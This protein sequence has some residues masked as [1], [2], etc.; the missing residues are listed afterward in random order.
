MAMSAGMAIAS[1]VFASL[2]SK[3][4]S[5]GESFLLAISTILDAFAALSCTQ[6]F[7]VDSNILAIALSITS[8]I[9]LY[10]ATVEL[11]PVV[12]ETEDRPIILFFSFLLEFYCILLLT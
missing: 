3:K 12:S 9:F 8:G 10:I 7:K 5:I 6:F 2:K 1:I 4:K 11:L